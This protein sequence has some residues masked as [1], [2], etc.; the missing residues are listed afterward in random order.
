MGELAVAKETADD[1]CAALYLQARACW[2]DPQDV[3]FEEFVEYL[4]SIWQRSDDS[5]V[6]EH[7]GDLYLVCGCLKGCPLATRVLVQ[8][9]VEP[10]L[11]ASCEAAHRDDLRQVVLERLLSRQAGGNSRLGEYAG[12][13]SL[14]TWLRVVI[15]RTQISLIRSQR[16]T[17]HEDSNEQLQNR[18]ISM[19]SDPEVDYLKVRYAH[20]FAQAFRVAVE[21]LDARDRLVLRMYICEGSR[22]RDVAQMLGVNRVTVVRWIAGIRH[23]LLSFTRAYLEREL[24]ITRAEFESVVRLVLSRVNLT[25]SSLRES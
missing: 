11:V 7:A 9:Y 8:Q 10:L 23:Q 16:H 4:S 14:R 18:L 1:S 24:Q 17:A 2:P 19:G 20:E 13:S 21:Q 12:R 15:K 25:L 5:S 3:T 6:V 22:A